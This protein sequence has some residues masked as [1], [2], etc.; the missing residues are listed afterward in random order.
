M[1]QLHRAHPPRM[2]GT[3]PR[4]DAVTP[5]DRLAAALFAWFEATPDFAGRQE[6]YALHAT[7][8]L[9]ADPTL[10]QDIED[11][12]ALRE[13]REALP[14]GWAWD[15]EHWPTREAIFQVIIRSA[16]WRHITTAAAP[17]IAEACDACRAT[18]VTL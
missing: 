18:L 8:V 2:D 9:R 13:L 12:R 16:D 17:T 1:W 6:E 15:I 14:D 4:G 3:G 11:G 10:A 7:G 5:R